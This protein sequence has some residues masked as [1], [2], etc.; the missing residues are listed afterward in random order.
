MPMTAATSAEMLTMGFVKILGRVTLY[1]HARYPGFLFKQVPTIEEAIAC[2]GTFVSS[3]KRN[4]LTF[5]YDL[6]QAVAA[7]QHGNFGKLSRCRQTV[8]PEE[9]SIAYGTN[10]A[11]GPSQVAIRSE[12][13]VRTIC[14][15][16]I[17]INAHGVNPLV[18]G[19]ISKASRGLIVDARGKAIP[20]GE[21][22]A[23]CAPAKVSSYA[24]NGDADYDTLTAARNSAI[25]PPGV[26]LTECL[27][28]GYISM[29]IP[30]KKK[31]WLLGAKAPLIA[32]LTAQ[33]VDKS[34]IDRY[35]PAMDAVA[36]T[37][38]ADAMIADE[39]VFHA[40]VSADNSVHFTPK[41]PACTL[42]AALP[43]TSIHLGYPGNMYRRAKRMQVA[44][45]PPRYVF[46]DAPTIAT[47]RATLTDTIT[48]PGNRNI[49]GIPVPQMKPAATQLAAALPIASGELTPDSFALSSVPYAKVKL[50]EGFEVDVSSVFGAFGPLAG[51]TRLATPAGVLDLSDRLEQDVGTA[52][53]MTSGAKSIPAGTKE[54][55]VEAA[56]EAA[57]IAMSE[58]AAALSE[59]ILLPFTYFVTKT[60]ASIMENVK[61]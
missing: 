9:P 41:R 6:A 14:D 26:S 7:G 56:V 21:E 45:D 19:I 16:P 4:V 13:S 35:G 50:A 33:G 58:A 23:S 48:I 29:A 2:G 42:K 38:P 51:P 61:A 31:E 3:E 43:F 55:N 39:L 18:V 52:I 47:M 57:S 34:I 22:L 28:S 20:V 40:C 53:V 60:N 5:G 27:L 11:Y 36:A 46:G 30:V 12:F 24:Y 1:R 8:R 37:I 25:L 49:D 32:K 59:N 44:G 15:L 54:E 10:M 17:W